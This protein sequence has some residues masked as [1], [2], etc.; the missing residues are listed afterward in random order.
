[1]TYNLGATP[2]GALYYDYD[3]AGHRTKVSGSLAQTNLPQPMTLA[4]YDGANELLQWD[5]GQLSYDA[6]GNILSDGINS[7]GWDAHS[8]LATIN[9]STVRYDA[10]GRRLANSAG[11]QFLYD[12]LNAVQEL[13]GS[14]AVSNRITGGLDEFF[15]RTDSGVSYAPLTDALGSTIALTNPAGSIT[16]QYRYDPFGNTTVSTL[17]GSPSANSF[18]Y[19]GRE[20]DGN[21]LYYYRARYYSPRLGRFL[22]NDP[23]GFF[24]AELSLYSYTGDSPV[25]FNDPYGTDKLECFHNLAEKGSLASVLGL[26][27]SKI[28]QAFLGNDISDVVKIGESLV[29]NDPSKFVDGATSVAAGKALETGTETAAEHVPGTLAYRITPIYAEQET[30]VGADYAVQRAL[31]VA[32]VKPIPVASVLGKAVGKLFVLKMIYDAGIALA[33]GVVCSGVLD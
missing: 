18:Q 26:G 30:V 2:L 8:Q 16:T 27:D 32:K 28:A 23:L 13:V 5:S 1:M 12:G 7:F 24:G 21:G 17:S 11:K 29:E 10:L 25:N 22:S 33:A 15:S 19:T 4:S 3:P 9:G 14:T 6:N 20:N 31:V